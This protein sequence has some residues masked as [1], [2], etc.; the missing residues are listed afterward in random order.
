MI[1]ICTICS[2]FFLLPACSASTITQAENT[3]KP[4]N[5][6]VDVAIP[7]N[8]K[9]KQISALQVKL[10][11]N[12]QPISDAEDVH[13]KIWKANQ[14]QESKQYKA[15]LKGVKTDHND[16]EGKVDHQVGS[17]GVYESK[18]IFQ[19]DGVYYVQAYVKAH[20]VDLLPTLRV[21]VGSLSKEELQ[22]LEKEKGQQENQAQHD[23]LHHH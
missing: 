9:P 1:N 8:V 7:E 2:V 15:V 4:A 5:I 13:L 20:G 22:A 12:N 14:E 6:N 10:T 11:Q 16:I 3:L 17:N 21:L 19:E 18:V 23:H